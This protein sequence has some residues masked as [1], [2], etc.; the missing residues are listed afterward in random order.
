MNRLYKSYANRLKIMSFTFLAFSF[1][2]L[3]KMFFIQSFE[4]SS[5][6]NRMQEIS[7][8]K[9]TVVGER[10][11]IYDRNSKILAVTIKKYIF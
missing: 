7:T 11:N 2:V 3:S 4:A 10:G 1:L 8:I 5:I 6:R 9:R